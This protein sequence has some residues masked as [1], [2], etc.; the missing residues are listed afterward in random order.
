LAGIFIEKGD[1]AQG[2]E[3]DDHAVGILDQF[4]IF[5]LAATKGG[6]GFFAGGDIP[7]DGVGAGFAG[8]HNF[9]TA[10]FGIDGAAV[11]P[12][13]FASPEMDWPDQMR[14]K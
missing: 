4:P 12:G 3:A 5:C 10:E 1:M 7:G 11:F 2:V 6:F 9:S 13:D 14:L 8:D